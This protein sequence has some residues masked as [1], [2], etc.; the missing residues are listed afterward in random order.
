MTNQ[1]Q[2]P[3]EKKNNPFDLLR[4]ILEEELEMDTE[5]AAF[6]AALKEEAC[7]VA[8][9]EGVEMDEEAINLAVQATMLETMLEEYPELT[10]ADIPE[11]QG[12]AADWV[13]SPL[14]ELNGLTPL[15]AIKITGYKADLEMI[16]SDM[17]NVPDGLAKEFMQ[18]ILTE[19]R[20]LLGLP[21]TP[22]P[23]TF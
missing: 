20:T 13:K 19:M 9:E 18:P 14:E 23:A 6:E 7:K 2:L 11:M 12:F 16:L 1:A 21:S 3:S 4:E 22:D 10:T 17:E 15:E 8:K 5:V